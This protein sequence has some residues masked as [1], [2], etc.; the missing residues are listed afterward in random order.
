MPAKKRNTINDSIDGA[1]AHPICHTQ[2]NAFAA[3]STGLRPYSSLSGA[4]NN[5]PMTYPSKYTLTVMVPTT[6]FVFPNS[7]FKLEIPGAKMDDA[8]GVS[9]VMADSRPTISHFLRAAK[10]SGMA[11]SSWDSHPTTPA[12]RSETGMGAKGMRSRGSRVRRREMMRE[13][14]DLA[15]ARVEVRWRA[16]E[17]CFAGGCQW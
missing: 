11:G 7:R 8:K 9:S 3:P 5:G 1:S 2:K 17:G 13:R 10:L 4:K 14:R 6:E 12:A 16:A 15:L